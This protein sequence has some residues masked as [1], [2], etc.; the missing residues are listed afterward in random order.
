MRQSGDDPRLG[1]TWATG[2]CSRA[3]PGL[4]PR[5]AAGLRPSS[6]TSIIRCPG[7]ILVNL[8]PT[9]IRKRWTNRRKQGAPSS[10]PR[11]EN[12]RA[13]MGMAE[14]NAG[15]ALL[16]REQESSRGEQRLEA[17]RDA[18][19]SGRRPKTAS[20]VR[21]FPHH[22]RG[23]RRVLRGVG[24]QNDEKSE[25]RRYNIAGITPAMTTLRC[26]RR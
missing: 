23:D 16:A 3:M 14:N 12:E 7:K 11:F 15:L 4:R 22:G 17:L 9:T 19:G 21:H 5:R 20:S 2:R 18:L 13:W 25:Y 6:I 26:A 10:L 24:R 1:V 8:D